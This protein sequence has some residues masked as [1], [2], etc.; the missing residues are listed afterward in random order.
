MRNS[1]E[2]IRIEYYLCKNVRSV[3]EIGQNVT[4]NR[5]KT[6]LMREISIPSSTDTMALIVTTA[7]DALPPA[8]YR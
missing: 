7:D 2:P 4:K 8:L 5:R 6:L 3:T 1:L